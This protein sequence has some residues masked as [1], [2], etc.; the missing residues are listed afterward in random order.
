MEWMRRRNR[1]TQRYPP[2]GSGGA[3]A[4]SQCFRQN[5]YVSA[6]GLAGHQDRLWHLPAE[7]AQQETS[8]VGGESDL[9]WPGGSRSDSALR[10]P[11]LCS[12]VAFSIELS[13]A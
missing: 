7:L 4:Q 2:R 1:P 13:A 9:A 12:E 8:A 6:L 11:S 3:E 10:L 5:W